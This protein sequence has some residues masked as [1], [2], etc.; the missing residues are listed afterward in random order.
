M[1]ELAVDRHAKDFGADGM[2]IFDAI[3]EGDDFGW[4]DKSEVEGIEEQGDPLALVIAELNFFEGAVGENC[5]SFEVGGFF[6]NEGH[7]ELRAGWWLKARKE[8][9][10]RQSA[11]NR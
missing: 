2:E 3:A 7:D 1:G 6:L 10:Q 11:A 5:L 8:S 9:K 4:A